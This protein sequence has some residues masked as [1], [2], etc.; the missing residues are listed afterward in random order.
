MNG[1]L[2][3]STNPIRFF[4]QSCLVLFILPFS[5]S[6]L[7]A[8]NVECPNNSSST[9]GCFQIN[10]L[11]NGVVVQNVTRICLGTPIQIVRC[12]PLVGD[13]IDNVSYDYDDTIS[14]SP[15]RGLLQPISDTTFT[16]TQPG[17]YSIKQSG[18][19]DDAAGIFCVSL[20][21]P[22]EVMPIPPPVFTLT[23]CTGQRV[24]L[25]I[26]AGDAS[27]PYEEYVVDWGDGSAVQTVPAGSV[28]KAYATTGAKTVTVTGR[29]QPGG[30]GAS[31]TNT[32]TPVN[33]LNLPRLTQL[34]VKDNN[35][36]ELAF[37]PTADF[38]TYEI[39]QRALPANPYELIQVLTNPA[40]GTITLTGL[41]TPTTTY[42]FRV[43]ALDACGQKI[44]LGEVCTVTLQASAQNQQNR[45]DWPV[46][47]LGGFSQ[48]RLYRNNQPIRNFTNQQTRQFTDT[49]VA[50]A[51]E[52]CYALEVR[53][54]NVTSLSQTT[55]VTAISDE[56]PT[57]LENLT[58]TVLSGQLVLAWKKPERFPVRFYRIER[59][60]NGEPFQLIGQYSGQNG[61]YVDA[62][63]SNDS[64]SYCYR[65]SYTDSCGNQSDFTGTACPMRLKKVES[66]AQPHPYQL[67]WS[68]YQ[69]WP[70]G[71]AS[72]TVE[73]LDADGNVLRSVDAGT[74]LNYSESERDTINQEVYFRIKAQSRDPLPLISYSNVVEYVQ[75]LRV[76]L[77]DAFTPNEDGLNDTYGAKGL[78]IRSFRMQVFNRWGEL[79]FVSDNVDEGWDGTFQGA[80]APAATYVCRIEAFDFRGKNLTKNKLFVLIR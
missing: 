70:S 62:Q 6:V 24:V 34:T 67:T 43:D 22:I 12:K 80:P 5:Y 65:V 59:S 76:Y 52:Y 37:L 48:Y 18:S 9:T 74:A 40:N 25:N 21:K 38:P 19:G 11:Q 4:Y 73:W 68:A 39:Y 10:A 32:V 41:N 61:Q 14:T 8:Q 15:T 13:Y 75:E 31:A 72:Y 50:C 20:R 77:P 64:V 36:V 79:L 56:K 47:P 33:A 54:G 42:C 51:R 7:K 78:F 23:A 69:N 44:S 66:P 63:V 35:S 30:C 53:A 17:K 2:S 49:D 55:C 46:Y 28:T 26:P 1:K 16:Y 60:D 3:F 57:V 27:N 71:V 45:V 29:Y 58:A